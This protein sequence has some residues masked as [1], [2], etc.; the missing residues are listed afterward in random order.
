MG[1][2]VG[3]FIPTNK[4]QGDQIIWMRSLC[5]GYPT[6]SGNSNTLP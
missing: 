5:P 3:P 2:L 4:N 6:G 1:S